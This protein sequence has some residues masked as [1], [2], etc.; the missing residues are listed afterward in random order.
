MICTF[1]G[2]RNIQNYN[3]VITK[4]YDTVC[5]LIENRG[6]RNFIVGNNGAFDRMVL[7]VLRTLS[8]SYD[9]DYMVVLSYLNNKN[10][11]YNDIKS[12]ESVYPE[13][14]EKTPKRY[15]IDKRN[16]WMIKQSDIAVIYIK[17]P[18]GNTVKY[19]EICEKRK[20]QI[21][22]LKWVFTSAL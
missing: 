1:F 8:K 10:D 19:A 9:I 2:S 17:D 6:I 20:M 3:E 14:L 16:R 22:K 15:A 21:I 18:F 5:D 4:L 13:F 12:C 7:K 11:E